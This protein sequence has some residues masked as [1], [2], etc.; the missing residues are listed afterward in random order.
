MAK[1]FWSGYGCWAQA[2]R[3]LAET[4]ANQKQKRPTERWFEKTTSG[5]HALKDKSPV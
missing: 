2:R 3:N 1:H 4:D 5:H